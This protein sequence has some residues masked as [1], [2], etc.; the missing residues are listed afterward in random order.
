MAR[1]AIVIGLGLETESFLVETLDQ[2]G[3]QHAERE[4]ATLWLTPYPAASSQLTNF[5]LQLDYDRLNRLYYDEH[6]KVWSGPNW[7]GWKEGLASNR[8]LGKL[9]IYEY[10]PAIREKVIEI[11][12]ALSENSSRRFN[13]YLI[14]H[15]HDPFASG[16]WLDLA[17]LL[18]SLARDQNGRT[19]GVLLLTDTPGDPL[20]AANDTEEDKRL[21]RA[22][23]YAAL[24]E[25]NFVSTPP[26]FYT[27]HHPDLDQKMRVENVS[28]FQSGD[29]YLLGGALDEASCTLDYERI[30]RNCAQFIY[31]QSVTSAGESIQPSN[32]NR[33]LISSFGLGVASDYK[34]VTDNEKTDRLV[35]HLLRRMLG[36]PV[37][38]D[39]ITSAD[40]S[41]QGWLKPSFAN[42]QREQFNTAK[43]NLGVIAA[44]DANQPTK[45]PA[46]ERLSM[47][48]QLYFSAVARLKEVETQ[49]A[50]A[51]AVYLAEAKREL[52][53]LSVES[54]LY[55]LRQSR[56]LTLKKLGSQYQALLARMRQKYTDEK[57]LLIQAEQQVETLTNALRSAQNRF[58]FV[59]VQDRNLIDYGLFGLLSTFF[60]AFMVV[61]G[62]VVWGWIWPLVGGIAAFSSIRLYLGRLQQQTEERYVNTQR[63]LITLQQ[64]IVDRRILCAYLYELLETLKDM[65]HAPSGVLRTEA[66]E[67]VI[68]QLVAQSDERHKQANRSS[69]NGHSPAT[70]MAGLD[71]QWLSDAEWERLAPLLID[72]LWIA[73][74]LDADFNAGKLQDVVGQFAYKHQLLKH[75][76]DDVSRLKEVMNAADDQT[77]CML[78]IKDAFVRESERDNLRKVACLVNWGK[79]PELQETQIFLRRPQLTSVD[80]SNDQGRSYDVPGKVVIMIRV[81]KNIPLRALQNL[82][83]EQYRICCKVPNSEPPLVLRGL[84]HPTRVGIASPDIM[85]EPLAAMRDFPPLVMA[86]TVFIRY[87]GTADLLQSLAAELTL[88]YEPAAKPPLD[89][90]ELCGALQENLPVVLRL[91]EGATAAYPAEDASPDILVA[92]ETMFD[93]TPPKSSELYADWEVWTV[94]MIRNAIQP[95]RPS[96]RD[97][98]NAK[99]LLWL[100]RLYTYLSAP[101]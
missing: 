31:L 65:L 9:S 15:L 23:C 86:L 34:R 8:M 29:C 44:A 96:R 21:R 39:P 3:K 47:L 84:L 81:R 72:E 51:A 1:R 100:C 49:Q 93:K 50:E 60:A 73:S 97:L 69:H 16:A 83:G 90:D 85:A 54:E 41:F 79:L 74:C 19:Y 80:L 87:L 35:S 99:A 95:E 63:E 70:K 64:Q 11:I 27:P 94:N 25:L 45:R 52:D 43:A 4:I 77:A 56:G 59:F 75:T 33:G 10:L 20:F 37:L 13:F 42:I 26:S 18:N 40:G 36:T 58:R 6:V 55:R 57:A 48:N 2:F 67:E 24:R 71:E 28:P 61:S 82:W 22:T 76:A 91:L 89:F 98:R 7:K 92:I 5:S 46:A 66:L 101:A 78:A 32:V 38:S 62:L 14:A 12:S 17:Y 53:S 30:R 68:Q 88:A